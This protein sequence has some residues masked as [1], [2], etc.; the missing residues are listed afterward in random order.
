MP[1]EYATFAKVEGNM[2]K[3]SGSDTL[4]AGGGSSS[5]DF[6]PTRRVREAPG[7]KSSISFYDEEE[8]DDALASAPSSKSIAV[9]TL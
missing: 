1:S 2:P 5:S 9:C 7:G 4:G 3:P 8:Q 6:V